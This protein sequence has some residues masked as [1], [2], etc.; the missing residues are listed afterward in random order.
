MATSLALEGE[1]RFRVR[2]SSDRA[3]AAAHR[4]RVRLC[5]A[6]LPR[7]RDCRWCDRATVSRH[8]V[9]M[10][11]QCL[12]PLVHGGA[13]GC[14]AHCCLRLDGRHHGPHAA[15]DYPTGRGRYALHL[16]PRPRPHD[17]RLALRP[18]LL[19]HAAFA[20]GTH[21]PSVDPLPMVGLC[22]LPQPRRTLAAALR[23]CS[24]LRGSVRRTWSAS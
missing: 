16:P 8:R 6:A 11:T 10:R 21:H 12:L 3:A 22:L 5:L 15:V 13:A 9:G 2:D 18:P 24:S 23:C 14:D 1:Y 7:E 17:E 19:P 20:R 4:R